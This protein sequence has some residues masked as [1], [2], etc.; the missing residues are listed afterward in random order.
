MTTPAII[1]RAYLTY[2]GRPPDAEGA[3]YFAD[4]TE[5]QMYETFAASQESK[6]LYGAVDVAFIVSK[7][8]A[9][10]PVLEIPAGYK[11][12][13]LEP[14]PEMVAAKGFKY[15]NYKFLS[16]ADADLFVAS[17]YKALVDAAPEVQK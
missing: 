5:Q 6:T 1:T 2:F 15:G 16:Q 12:V 4:K 3:A 10:P 17:C 9:A 14:T 7:I 11:I 8:S 13:L